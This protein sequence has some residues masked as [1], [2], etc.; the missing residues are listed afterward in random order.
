LNKFGHYTYPFLFRVP[1]IFSLPRSTMWRSLYIQWHR[2]GRQPSSDFSGDRFPAFAT[3]RIRRA[4]DRFNRAFE[5]RF[6]A[7][8]GGVL[9]SPIKLQM[10]V[11]CAHS[12]DCRLPS[13][14]DTGIRGLSLR[15][16]LQNLDF[17]SVVPIPSFFLHSPRML[18]CRPTAAAAVRIVFSS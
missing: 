11:T 2:A 16:V 8:L 6:P 4:Q 12:S 5:K 10:W 13:I 3:S 9:G 1:N 14:G 18:C 15:I 17:Q 7:A